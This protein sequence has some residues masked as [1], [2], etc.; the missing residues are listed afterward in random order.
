MV[1][2]LKLFICLLFSMLMLTTAY[3][4]KA[5]S[6]DFGV[7]D[8][9]KVIDNY[10]QAQEVAAEI[11]VK[12]A[13]LQ[14]FLMDAQKKVKEAKTPV[15]KKNLEERLGEEFNIKR[16]AFVKE[17][18]E[19]WEKVENNIFETIEELHKKNKFDLTFNQKSVIIGG[20]DITEEVIKE[21]NKNAKQ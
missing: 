16:N 5:K 8:L 17:Q 21:L 18:S 11:K 2:A 4:A 9:N 10:T 20:T 13:E 3:T 19:K 6:T 15:E 1:R 12:E 7:V 14:K